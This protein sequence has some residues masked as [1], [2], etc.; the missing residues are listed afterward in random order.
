MRPAKLEADPNAP[1]SKQVF[2]HWRKTFE[3]FVAVVENGREVNDP[4]I[5]KYGLL[6][7][8]VSSSV[9]NYI[10]QITNYGQAITL[11]ER[12]YIKPRNKIM[13]RHLL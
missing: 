10:Q 3:R 6:I 5:D 12:T 1:D 4:E 8:Y 7:N 9:Y 2:K 11:L 13:A